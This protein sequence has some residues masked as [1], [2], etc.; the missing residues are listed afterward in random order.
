MAEALFEKMKRQKS[1]SNAPNNGKLLKIFLK[2]IEDS[3]CFLPKKIKWESD[4][5]LYILD[6]DHI[7]MSLLDNES[8]EI[9]FFKTK[10]VIEY[11]SFNTIQEA[12]LI[13]QSFYS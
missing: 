6:W 2:E 3:E 12:L 8:G 11:Y 7:T 5:E 9:T 10:D 13:L 1:F 4:E